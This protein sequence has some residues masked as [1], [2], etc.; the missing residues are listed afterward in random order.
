MVHILA[1]HRGA[2]LPLFQHIKDRENQILSVPWAP[3]TSLELDQLIVV[4]DEIGVT[5]VRGV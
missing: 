2:R 4:M 3:E 5:W 1:P